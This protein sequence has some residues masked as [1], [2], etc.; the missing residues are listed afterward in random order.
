MSPTASGG[1]TVYTTFPDG[2]WFQSFSPQ[3]GLG[4]L[5]TGETALVYFVRNTFAGPVIC[6]TPT[7]FANLL[8][9]RAA[10]AAALATLHPNPAAE[11]ATLTLAQPARAAHRLHLT[12]ALGRTV[13]STSLTAGQTTATV[14]L[15]GQPAGL[16][17]LHLTGSGTNGSWK[18]THD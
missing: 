10:E 12:D 8:P 3:L 11:A 7:N 13:W 1:A 5:L 17:L 2:N 18:I 15:A 9:T 6:G 4:P 14:P 16:Y